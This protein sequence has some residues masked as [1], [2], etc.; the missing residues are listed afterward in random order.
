M[1]AFVT[2]YL[3]VWLALTLYVLRLRA[4]QHRQRRSLAA[5]QTQLEQ[6]GST[7]SSTPTAA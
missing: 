6:S 5:L 3:A 1:G 2:A 4:H 7:E